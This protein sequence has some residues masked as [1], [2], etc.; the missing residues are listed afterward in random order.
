MG[1][2][3]KKEIRAE[4]KKDGEKRMKRRCMKKVCRSLTV[5]GR[6][7]LIEM[8]LCC[9]PMWTQKGKWKPDF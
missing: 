1:M 7:P 6:L 4:V 5:S 9:W 3:G 2:L 8:L